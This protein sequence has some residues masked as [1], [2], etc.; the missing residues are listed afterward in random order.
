MR[1]SSAYRIKVLDNLLQR[2]WLESQGM[3][4][5]NLE[6]FV[7][8]DGQ[9]PSASAGTRIGTQTFLLAAMKVPTRM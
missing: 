9:S 5:I 8:E 1:A 7:L 3:R 4:Q 2:Y 6:S